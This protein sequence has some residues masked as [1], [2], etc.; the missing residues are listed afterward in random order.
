MSGDV[1]QGKRHS[2]HKVA[3]KRQ[4]RTLATDFHRQMLKVKKKKAGLNVEGAKNAK[5]RI[6]ARK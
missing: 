6:D 2:S 4:K 3:K 1:L 5:E